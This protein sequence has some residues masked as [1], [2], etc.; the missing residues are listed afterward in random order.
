MEASVPTLSDQHPQNPGI[1]WLA[2][3]RTLLFQVLVLLALAVAFAGYV[4]WSSN[5]TWAEFVAASTPS[6]LE[7]G[8]QAQTSTAVH[9]VKNQTPCKPK[10]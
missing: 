5:E 9:T 2:V 6:A 8:H 7:P 3:M 4:E 10:G 1:N